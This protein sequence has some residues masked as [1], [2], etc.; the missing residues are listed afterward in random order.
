MKR[1]AKKLMGAILIIS[2]AAGCGG[3]SVHAKDTLNGY[4]VWGTVTTNSNSATATTYYSRPGTLEAKATV[5]FVYGQ[6]NLNANAGPNTA[7]GGGVSATAYVSIPGSTVIGG[8]GEHKVTAGG[9]W[10]NISRT[11]YTE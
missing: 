7:S 10:T 8:K 4:E 11:G 2:L 1:F 3:I 6:L 5:Y 9:T